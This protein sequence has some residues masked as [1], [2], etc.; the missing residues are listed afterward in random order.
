M[1]V[2]SVRLWCPIEATIAATVV[3]V[4]FTTFGGRPVARPP[5]LR[6]GYAFGRLDGDLYPL[7]ESSPHAAAIEGDA[8][9]LQR[10]RASR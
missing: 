5:T 10:R 1:L 8:H 9:S 4:Q 6:R 7:T 3:H 2:R